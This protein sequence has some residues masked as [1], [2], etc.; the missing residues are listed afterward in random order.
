MVRRIA[1]SLGFTVDLIDIASED[2]L[3]DQYGM[4]IPILL[5][6]KQELGWPFDEDELIAWLQS[7]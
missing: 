6:E 2:K 4:Q 3:V 5:A 7:L 1:P